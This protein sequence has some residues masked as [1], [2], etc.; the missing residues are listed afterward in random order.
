MF[1]TL[2]QLWKRLPTTRRRQFVVVLALIVVASATEV[3]AVGALLPFLAVFATPERIF[4]MP[5]LGPLIRFL[6]IQTPSGLLLPVTILLCIGSM[7]SAAARLLLLYVGTRVSFATGAELSRE[8]YRRTLYQPYAVHVMQNSAEAIS[9]IVGKTGAVVAGAFQPAMAM[10][11][12][13]IIG[14]AILGA[15]VMLD[16]K[17]ALSTL[18]GISG[19]YWVIS[20]ATRSRLRRNGRITVAANT[21]VYQTLQEG[22]G[23][24]RDILLD[25]SQGIYCAAYWKAEYPARRAAGNSSFLLQSPRYL[26]E[27][28]GI[29]LIAGIAWVFKAS[30]DSADTIPILGALALGTQ[31]LLPL[32]QQAYMAW[33]TMTASEPAV[34]DAIRLLDQPVPDHAGEPP[35]TPIPF[36]R[37]F[38]LRE[39]NFRYQKDGPWVLRGTNLEIRKGARIGFK[40]LTGSGKSTLMDVVMGLL[41]P[42]EGEM[43][44]DGVAITSANRRSWQVRIAHVPQAIYLADCSIAQNI[45]FGVPDDAIDMRR[46]R[47]AAI[48]AQIGDF[49]DGLP[50]GYDSRIGE[51][52]VRLSGGQRQ[53]IGIAR[54]LY[55]KAS[56]IIFDEATSALDSETEA[57]VM[58]AIEQLEDDLTLLIVAHRLST[59]TVCDEV[60]DLSG[61]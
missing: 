34:R 42:T 12:S 18:A 49:I 46:V 57:A 22:L 17:L 8:V 39:V 4:G 5:A 56:V 7:A 29:I 20:L 33:G 43:L 19:I 50:Q 10:A 28:L 15:L 38:E 14:L 27:G 16:P 51:R 44:V 23:G 25:G 61:R 52:G 26:V 3:F 59:L 58:E 21:K 54:A 30:G 47:E 6:G 41:E 53:R 13:A 35:A 45:A 11:S 24:I 31:K 40:G 2:A 60:V 36:E 48:K 1:E 55:K 37:S 9:G 32:V